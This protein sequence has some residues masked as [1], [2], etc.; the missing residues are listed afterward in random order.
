[1]SL[2]EWIKKSDCLNL[3][4][5]SVICFSLPQGNTGEHWVVTVTEIRQE[6]IIKHKDRITCRIH[7]QNQFHTILN[8]IGMLLLWVQSYI[9]HMIH[10]I[11]GNNL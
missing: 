9:K 4:S 10:E 8:L 1:M 11:K 7:K 3:W 5:W 6:N 2:V